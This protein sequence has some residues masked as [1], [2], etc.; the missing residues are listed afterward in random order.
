[1]YYAAC[2]RNEDGT[3]RT[4]TGLAVSNDLVD[5]QDAGW[6]E[7]PNC[8]GAIESPFVT[9]HND[10]YYL[11]YT[12]TSKSGTSYAYSKN[13]LSGWTYPD[14]DVLIPGVSC[15]EVVHFKDKDYISVSTNQINQLHF[16]GFYEFFWNEDGTIRV[17]EFIR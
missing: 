12:N 17:G 9:K 10:I 6:I 1:M 8:S 15:S 11:F 13:P 14:E 5:W 7:H 16:I 2:R 3:G 4:V